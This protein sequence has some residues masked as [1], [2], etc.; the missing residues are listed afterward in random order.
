[1]RWIDEL[2]DRARELLPP[3]VTEYFGQGA[4]AGMSTAEAAAAWDALRLRPRVLRDVSTVSTATTVL[5]QP[6][7]TPVLV[8]PTTLQRLAHDEGESATARGAASA[9][10]L[11]EVSTNAGT[12]FEVL[13]RQGAPWW[14]QAYIVRDRGF[15]VEV[16]KRAKAAGAGAVVLTVDTPEVGHKLQAGDSVWDLVTGDQLQANL[17]TDGLPDGAL[18]KARDLTF[19]DIGWLRETVGLPVVVKGVLRGDD[20]RECVAAGAAAV[21]VSNHGGRQLDG[22]VSTA[23]ALPEI[24]RAL[25]GTGA[26]V[27]V[28][29]G[30]RRG[31]HILAAL[32]LGATAVFVGRPVLWAL[33]V[34]GAD[35]VR[36]LLADLTG[37][38][39]HAMTLAGA[40][41]LD[42]LAPDLVA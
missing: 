25:D 21:Q 42:D 36:R 40:A 18:D 32:A 38:L 2:P 39:R 13:G 20:A 31:S 23:R 15:S 19:A 9:G 16:L 5:G 30:L 22:A 10:S 29:G 27:Y 24:V 12:R 28:D 4:A 34:D 3:P 41:S 6:V 35:G 7:D 17:D 14:V 33:T 37:E 26:E 1:M 8:A 11:L